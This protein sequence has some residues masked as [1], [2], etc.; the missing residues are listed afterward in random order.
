MGASCNVEIAKVAT[1]LIS[2]FLFGS[3]IVSLNN[4][5]RDTPAQDVSKE[6]KHF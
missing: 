6:E 4:S 3:K 5:V 2:G 1:V